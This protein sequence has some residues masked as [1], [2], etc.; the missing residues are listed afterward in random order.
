MA[1]LYKA[2]VQNSSA[3]FVPEG[4][5]SGTYI[6]TGTDQ[7]KF[8]DIPEAADKIATHLNVVDYFFTGG[9]ST[10]AAK[11]SIRIK[12]EFR[13][14]MGGFLPGMEPDRDAKSFATVTLHDIRRILSNNELIKLATKN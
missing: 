10:E 11:G 13:P 1:K 5:T 3:Y 12:L 9:Y 8:N 2:K 7:V 14:V 4:K 6:D